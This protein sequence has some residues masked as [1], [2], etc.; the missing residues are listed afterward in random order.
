MNNIVLNN[1]ELES[2]NIIMES[3]SGVKLLHH[4]ID[5]SPLGILICSLN[6]KVLFYNSQLSKTFTINEPITQALKKELSIDSLF[7]MPYSPFSIEHPS[8]P[9]KVEGSYI[10]NE[11]NEPI[12]LILKMQSKIDKG[13]HEL[14]NAIMA[15]EGINHLLKTQESNDL[16]ALLAHMKKNVAIVKKFILE[17]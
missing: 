9:L 14:R 1:K 17:A 4:L 15:L 3:E 6:Q 12:A 8:K 7:E 10:L 13:V 5:P 2:F 16:D 11:H